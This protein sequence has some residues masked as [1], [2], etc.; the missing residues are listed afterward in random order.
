MVPV[1]RPASA[2]VYPRVKVD[3]SF[4][5]YVTQRAAGLLRLAY[6]LTGDRGHAE[7]LLQSALLRTAVHWRK[8]RAAPDAYVRRVLVNLSR[9]RA[10]ARSRRPP[11]TPLPLDDGALPA[12]DAGLDRIG[13][14]GMV[15]KALAALPD[16]Q[17]QA[18]VLRYYA[19]LSVEETA[20]VMRCSTG[21]VKSHTSRA[22][23]R[24]REV[25]GPEIFTEVHHAG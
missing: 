4:D 25:L 17:R 10:R 12:V 18:V 5:A 1:N 3:P 6:L 16:R 8:A 15:T 7:D 13:Q 23:A 14:H 9:D 21:A 20:A 11:E 19:D 22:V 2:G 24:L